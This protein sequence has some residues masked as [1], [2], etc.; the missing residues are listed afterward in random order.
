VTTAPDGQRPELPDLLGRAQELARMG[1]RVFPIEPQSKVA[2]LQRWQDQATDDPDALAA[3]W[4]RPGTKYAGANLALLMGCL[5]NAGTA[6][7]VALDVDEREAFSGSD[8]LA[9]LEHEWG[10]LPDTVRQESGS[11]NGSHH[12]LLLTPPEVDLTTMDIGPGVLLKGHHGYIVG[13]GSIHDRTGQT[14]DW[15]LGLEPP[16]TRVGW[17]PAGWIERLTARQALAQRARIEHP[18]TEDDDE[19]IPPWDELIRHFGGTYVGAKMVDGQPYA[20]YLRPPNPEPPTSELSAIVMDH[21][22]FVYTDAWP[23]RVGG[24]LRPSQARGNKVYNRFAFYTAMTQGR[25]TPEAFKVARA[26]LGPRRPKGDVVD[27]FGGRDRPGPN[28]N[29]AAAQGW[30]PSVWQ[31]AGSPPITAPTEDEDGLPESWQP[32]DLGPILDGTYV[33]P[34][35]TLL[36]RRDGVGLFYR[37]AVN[38]IHGESGIGKSWIATVATKAELEA[39][40][41]VMIL[42]YED[43]AGTMVDRLRRLQVA[44]DVIRAR[45]IYLRPTEPITAKVLD[46]LCAMIASRGVSMVGLDSVGEALAVE[47]LNEDKDNEVAPWNRLVPRRLADAGT[48]VLMVDHGTKAGDKPLHPS[49]SKRKRAAFTGSSFYVSSDQHKPLGK[50]DGDEPYEGRL[51]MVCA[52]DRHGTHRQGQ[53]AA[54]L[55]VTA[56]P[57]GHLEV[58]IFPPSDQPGANDPDYVTTLLCAQAAVNVCREEGRQLSLRALTGLMK[59]NAKAELKRAGIELAVSRGALLETPGPNR[60]RLFSFIKELPITG[61]GRN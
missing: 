47:G 12:I 18:E 59:I 23:N 15:Q 6:R 20:A 36:R 4:P 27:I 51:R 58:A 24:F 3:L 13:P 46:H 16:E 14:Y 41:A 53:V 39:G 22:L 50:A 43:T 57:D 52:K 7:L 49:G 44:D 5:V 54:D 29:H 61:E 2:Y 38:G 28:P 10:R 34:T 17:M 35:P 40:R 11:R 31:P 48:A 1:F 56:F 19:T 30:H 26:E 42:D 8:T 37:E 33:A 55:L 21:G 9:L 60:A 25:L 32:V 45:L